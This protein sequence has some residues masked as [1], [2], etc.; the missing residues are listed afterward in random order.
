MKSYEKCTTSDN[1]TSD[2]K[3]ITELKQI[4]EQTNTWSEQYL[5]SN[6]GPITSAWNHDV[7]NTFPF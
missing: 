1:T 5:N 6:N 3:Q 2:N 7:Y 4:L